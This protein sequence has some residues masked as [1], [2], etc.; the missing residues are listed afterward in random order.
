[1]LD[2]V[3]S[4]M[5]CKIEEANQVIRELK[6]QRDEQ[7]ACASR[8]FAEVAARDTLI[9]QLQA[10]LQEHTNWALRN[11]ERV[12]DLESANRLLR[13]RLAGVETPGVILK[14]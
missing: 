6:R 1:M 8:N 13:T 10:Q 11:V 4:E 12:K 14:Q 3:Q 9:R 5:Q 2:A 7:S